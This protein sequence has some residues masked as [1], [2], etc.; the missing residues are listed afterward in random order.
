MTLCR[1]QINYVYL[2]SN[3]INSGGLI[4]YSFPTRIC[5]SRSS[6]P[7]ESLSRWLLDLTRS[8]YKNKKKNTSKDLKSTYVLSLCLVSFIYYMKLVVLMNL[9]ITMSVWSS[10]T[11]I[12]ISVYTRTIPGRDGSSKINHLLI[13]SL[14][15]MRSETT[16]HKVFTLNMV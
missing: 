14:K 7:D 13:Q 8:L 1:Y 15:M 16:N 11:I 2:L 12:M 9:R 10:I 6:S 4:W 5:P 3:G